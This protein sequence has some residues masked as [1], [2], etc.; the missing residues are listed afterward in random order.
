MTSL[1]GLGVTWLLAPLWQR[2][3]WLTLWCVGQILPI[4]GVLYTERGALLQ[5]QGELAVRTESLGLLLQK[6]AALP[7]LAELNEGI[8]AQAQRRHTT[9]LPLA[10]LVVSPLRESGSRMLSWSSQSTDSLESVAVQ[11]WRL[12]V[13]GDYAALTRF[14]QLLHAMDTPGISQLTMG[15]DDRGIQMALLLSEIQSDE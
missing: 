13:T 11:R 10:Q 15:T 1:V 12:A 4:G 8:A 3:F 7:T 5:V 6:V 14:L 9:A 2:I